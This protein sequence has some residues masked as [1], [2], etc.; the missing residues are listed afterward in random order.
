MKLATYLLAA[1]LAISSS[2]ATAQDRTGLDDA[3]SP[4]AMALDLVV[5]RPLGLAATLLGCAVYIVALPIALMRGEGP[6]EPAQ[7]LVVE[8][9]A[10]TFTRRLGAS[11]SD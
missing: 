5:L 8:P 7:K 9:A 4:G 3:P 2:L 1:V 11:S 6:L 10:F